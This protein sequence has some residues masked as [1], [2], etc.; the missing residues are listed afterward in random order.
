MQTFSMPKYRLLI[1][2]HTNK[3]EEKQDILF[4]LVFVNFTHDA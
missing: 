2:Q 4:F 1:K 3:E